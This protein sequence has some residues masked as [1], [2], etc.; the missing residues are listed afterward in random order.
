MRLTRRGK[1]AAAGLIIVGMGLIAA[2]VMIGEADFS[3]SWI[4]YPGCMLAL[5]G[6]WLSKKG[7]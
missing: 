4:S 6:V 2:G 7:D 3:K 1:M 5:A